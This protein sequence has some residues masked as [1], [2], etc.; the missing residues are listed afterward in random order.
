M[1]AYHNKLDK[2]YFKNSIYMKKFYNTFDITSK[3]KKQLQYDI[4][5]NTYNTFVIL[6]NYFF[7]TNYTM[8][9][10]ERIDNSIKVLNDYLITYK[11][12]IRKCYDKQ[13]IE[14]YEDFEIVEGK[15]KL[16]KEEYKTKK[17]NDPSTTYQK[18]PLYKEIASDIEDYMYL[19][20]LVDFDK[21]I[22]SKDMPYIKVANDKLPR[23]VNCKLIADLNT[24]VN[25][26]ID[27]K[28]QENLNKEFIE[29]YYKDT[30]IDLNKDIE[31]REFI[32]ELHNIIKDLNNAIVDYYT[33][34]D[35]T[36]IFLFVNFLPRFFNQ[37]IKYVKDI[38][39]KTLFKRVRA[40]FENLCKKDIDIAYEK[41]KDIINDYKN[42]YEYMS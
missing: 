8:K 41:L 42:I 20:N 2:K 33:T 27:E 18:L 30:D 9:T 40:I 14:M 21:L 11:N 10:S 7:T 16:L 13:C 32:F 15:L 3:D 38:R 17:A 39:Y 23:K 28:K 5:Y 22:D 6:N 1:G 34:K 24:K 31:Q 35:T 29:Q 12:K 26:L 36:I 37:D 19:L 25:T 4:V